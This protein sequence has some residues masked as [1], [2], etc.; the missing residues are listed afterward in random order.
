MTANALALAFPGS[1][2]AAPNLCRSIPPTSFSSESGEADWRVF[3][4]K[5]PAP[6]PGRAGR[7]VHPRGKDCA[8]LS[9]Q[10]LSAHSSV[11][12]DWVCW[13][14]QILQPRLPSEAA[15]FVPSFLVGRFPCRILQVAGSVMSGALCFVDLAFRLKLC[16]TGDF[17]GGILVGALSPICRAL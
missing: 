2:S 17:A 4:A 14:C 15:E 12:S 8:G 16:I 7:R 5:C 1:C 10:V 11:W 13:T 6:T 3:Q 9:D